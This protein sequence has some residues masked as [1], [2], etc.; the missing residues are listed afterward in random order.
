[1]NKMSEFK[2]GFLSEIENCNKIEINFV[3]KYKNMHE[4]KMR[5]TIL[6]DE[7]PYFQDIIEIAKKYAEDN[8]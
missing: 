7:I 1:M 3:L 6:N 4:R 5:L 2:L 8:F